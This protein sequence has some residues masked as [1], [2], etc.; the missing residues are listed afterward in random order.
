MKKS[1]PILACIFVLVNLLAMSSSASAGR[2]Q[3]VGGKDA[4]IRPKPYP[5][6]PL[7]PAGG[8]YVDPTFGTTI[9]RVTDSSNAPRGAGLNSSAQDSMFNA[10]GT[11]FYLLHRE[12]GWLLYS[13]DRVAGQVS[14]LGRLPDNKGFAYDG[15]PWD[16]TDPKVLYAI[17]MSTT[18]RELWQ[19]TLPSSRLTLLH[20]FSAEVPTGGYPYSRVQISPDS[21]YFA[22]TA[23]TTGGQD[24]FDYVVVWDR[25]TEKTKVLNTRSRLGTALHSMVLDGTGTYA[26]LETGDYSRTYIWHWP[27]DTLSPALGIGRPYFF[28]GH[29]VIGSGQVVS[30]GGTA[31]TWLV[32]S[33][34]TPATFSE[35]LHYPRKNGKGNWFEDSH[36]S[37][38]LSGGTFFQT[39]YV[40]SFGWGTFTLH[41]G[42]VYKLVG[43]RKLSMDFDAPEAVRYDGVP[44]GRVSGVPAAPG[45]WSYDP[46]AD[47][48]Y[49]WLSDH[50]NPQ[51]NRRALSIFDWRPLM[52]EIIQVW[53]D[54][55]STKLRRLAHHRMHFTGSFSTTPRG[56]AD[57]TGSFVLFQS[58]WDG[59]PRTDVFLLLVPD[60]RREPARHSALPHRPTPTPAWLSR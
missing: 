45:Q 51:A 14:V 20:N 17:V 32:R 29:K 43:F 4:E 30:P 44:L 35:V 1:I 31:G 6:P 5:A 11:M 37:R 25:Q 53:V 28:G 7:P 36:S 39:R 16:P 19:I 22:I 10:D 8:H 38:L 60:S 27:S 18:R 52:E 50:S 47:T 26:L 57:P 24:T 34:A 55:S 56:N 40:G 54:G 46:A 9:I 58:N 21:R 42:S 12:V 2:A 15:A 13:L 41:T 48:L 3:S 49:L 59:S 33:L 23:S